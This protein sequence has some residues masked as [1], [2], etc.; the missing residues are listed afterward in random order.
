MG[1]AGQPGPGTPVCSLPFMAELEHAF[2]AW[3]A[4]ESHPLTSVVRPSVAAVIPA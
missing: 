3:F 2:K 4:L 1:Q